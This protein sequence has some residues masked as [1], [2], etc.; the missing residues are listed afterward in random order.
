MKILLDTHAFIWWDSKST[1][2]S[3]Q[4]LRLIEDPTNELWLSAASIWEMNIK[5]QSSKLWFRIPL[6]DIILQQV[7]S[8]L[9]LLPLNPEHAMRV[10][11]LPA[12]H[13]D[14][15]DR[16]LIIQTIIENATLISKD[17]VFQH[18]QVNVIW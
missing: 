15:F 13:K 17:S 11:E 12:H 1:Q 3:N 10:H 18:Y 16:M 7:T 9:R 4:A 5:S 8:G 14:P 2:L 6:Q